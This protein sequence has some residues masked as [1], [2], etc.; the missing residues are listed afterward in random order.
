MQN[1]PD[2]DE[3]VATSSSTRSDLENKIK[4]LTY[5]QN[6]I[7]SIEITEHPLFT[8]GVLY[9]DISFDLQFLNP[10]ELPLASLL[11]NLYLEMGTNKEDYSSLSKRI[12]MKT[13]GIN[14]SPFISPLSESDQS[15]KRFFLRGNV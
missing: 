2:S 8:N 1:K 3:T 10:Q 15:V 11:S 14:G 6:R 13:G 9:V 5:N 7:N 4:T 12:A